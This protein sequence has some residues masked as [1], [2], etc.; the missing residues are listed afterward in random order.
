METFWFFG[1]RFHRACDS[2]YDCNFWFSLN[3]TRENQRLRSMHHA[4]S[5]LM[6]YIIEAENLCLSPA[7]RKWEAGVFKNLHSGEKKMPFSVTV[8]T[9]YVW[10]PCRP[11]RGKIFVFKQKRIHW[12]G[13]LKLHCKHQWN[14]RWTF[15]RKHDTF[16]VKRSALLWLHNKTM[17]DFEE[18]YFFVLII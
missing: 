16:T 6:Y 10:T 13:G 9:G 2:A 3:H 18:V 15:A 17:H 8:F 5:I 14:T 7:T 1:L 12:E 4:R 11:N